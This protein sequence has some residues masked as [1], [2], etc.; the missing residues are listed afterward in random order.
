MFINLEK[1]QIKFCIVGS[2]KTC[3]VFADL[4]RKFNFPDP[5]VVTWEKSLH[6]RD[7]SIM[8][9]QKEYKDI[10][11]YCSL[12]NICIYEAKNIN[13]IETINFLNKK[14]INMIISLASRWIFRENIIKVFKGSIFNLHH[15]L[16]PTERGSTIY[17]R[18]MNNNN[19]ISASLHKIS[20]GIDTGNILYINSKKTTNKKYSISEVNAINLEISKEILTKFLNDLIKKKEIKEKSQK[21]D[22]GIY[23]P[24]FHTETNGAIDW[25]WEADEI[26]RFMRAFGSPF[27]GAFTYYKNQ[28]ISLLEGYVEVSENKYHPYFNGRIVNIKSDKSIKIITNKNYLIVNKITFGDF[29]GRPGEIIKLS[30]NAVFHTPLNI[31]EKSKTNF[32]SS[33]KMKPLEE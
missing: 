27:P 23:M 4:L 16:L 10:F 5:V 14:G 1:D 9:N 7:Q 33:L 28:K 2:G 18:I 30:S 3:T 20:D 22:E 15:G 6:K 8:K 29:Q 25:N 21:I 31:L 26:E 19:I 24:I 32:I 13:N 11:E 17:P 12:N